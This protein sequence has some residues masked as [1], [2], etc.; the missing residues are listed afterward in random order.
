GP[1]IYRDIK[2]SVAPETPAPPAIADLLKSVDSEEVRQYCQEKGWIIPV[3]ECQTERH[4]SRALT[5]LQAVSTFVAVAG[6]IYIVYKLFAG[7]Q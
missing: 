2:I 6:C 4:L 1:P 7:F 5:I 3:T